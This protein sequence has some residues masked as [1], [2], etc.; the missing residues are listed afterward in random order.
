MNRTVSTDSAGP[1]LL[2]IEFQKQW[3]D[4]G[5]YHRLIKNQLRKNRVLENTRSLVRKACDRNIPVI[6]APLVIDP[7]KKKGWLARLTFGQVF[8]RGT[9]KAE[10][11]DGMIKEGDRIVTGR[12]ALDAFTGSDL[13]DI[14]RALNVTVV[15]VCGFSTDQCVAKTMKTMERKGFRPVMVSDCTATFNGILQKMTE[16]RFES[17][18]SSE[19]WREK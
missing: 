17:V 3:T 15:Y 6:H 18:S 2:L 10:F 12:Y 9:W 13:E 14:L 16:R 4:R 5:I 8:T 11:T 7:A 19:I 1:A